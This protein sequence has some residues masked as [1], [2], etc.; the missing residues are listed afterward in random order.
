MFIIW[1]WKNIQSPG[2]RGEFHCPN[3]SMP[4]KYRRRTLRTW[5]TLY[6]IPV[7]PLRK[8]AEYVQCQSC[9]GTFT[10]AVLDRDPSSNQAPP[11]PARAINPSSALREGMSIEAVHRAL[12]SEGLDALSGRDKVDRAAGSRRKACVSCGET[13][14][15]SIENC[16]CGGRLA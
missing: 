4:Q 9:G 2:R 6:F 11:R 12:V 14:H 7:I 10:P 13:Y 5:F 3:C 1:G 8:V 15:W 16:P